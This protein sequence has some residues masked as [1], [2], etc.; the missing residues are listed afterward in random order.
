MKEVDKKEVKYAKDILKL[1]KQIKKHGRF[2]KSLPT[3]EDQM[4]LEYRDLAGFWYEYTD[5][6]K[7]NMYF[8][9]D[10]LRVRLK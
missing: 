10:I 6:L 7:N 2:L 1:N 8:H 9:P 3:I 5:Q 4:V